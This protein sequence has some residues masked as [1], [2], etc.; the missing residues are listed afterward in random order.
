MDSTVSILA[1]QEARRRIAPHVRHTPLV[2]STWLSQ[3]TGADVRLKLETL[4]PTSAF[5]VRGAFNAALRLKE[6]RD[7][8]A[9]TSADGD[10]AALVTASA[11]NHG[12][13]LATAAAAAGLPCVV[14][15]P[16][17]AP[18]V[19]LD[20]ISAAGAQLYA[21]S[22]NYDEAERAA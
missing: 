4:Q 1:V 14:F 17:D 3:A 7:R 18:K 20:K 13:A 9:G 12:M 10:A 5:K 11:G 19:K 15:T 22:R 2:R 6:E 21:S 8:R 16:A